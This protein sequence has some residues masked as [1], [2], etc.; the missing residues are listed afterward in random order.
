[1]VTKILIANRGEIDCP[2]ITT[3]RVMGIANVAVSSDEDCTDLHVDKNDET[4]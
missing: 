3:A 1:M 2:I 4:D